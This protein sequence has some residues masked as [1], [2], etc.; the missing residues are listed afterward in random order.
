MGLLSDMVRSS[1]SR[2]A[3]A[4]KRVPE[5][6]LRAAAL[7]APAAPRLKLGREGFDVMA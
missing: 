1:I 6:A 2:V 7:A 5:A 4:R 3:E